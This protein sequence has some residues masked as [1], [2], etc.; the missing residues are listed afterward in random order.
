MAVKKRKSHSHG[1]AE[2]NSPRRK[3]WEQG[4]KATSPGG[5]AESLAVHSAFFRR[6]AAWN[7][8]TSNP[9][10]DAVGYSLLL[11]RSYLTPLSKPDL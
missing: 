7:P 8:Q 11:L 6:Y 9:T 10:A 4:Q 3:L 5:A 1:V 2:D